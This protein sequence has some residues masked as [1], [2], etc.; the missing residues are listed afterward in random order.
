MKKIVL[1]AVTLSI[2]LAGC[3]TTTLVRDV[4]S[5]D[6]QDNSLG[7]YTLPKAALGVDLYHGSVIATD[8]TTKKE[9]LSSDGF[10]IAAST[11]R[12]EAGEAVPISAIFS[13]SSHDKFTVDVD[14]A[15]GFL[16]RI[17]LNIEDKSV[18]TI[19]AAAASIGAIA[20]FFPNFGVPGGSRSSAEAAPVSGGQSRRVEYA[21]VASVVVDPTDPQSIAAAN[22]ALNTH[23]EEYLSYLHR[24]CQVNNGPRCAR[25]AAWRASP[26][27]KRAAYEPSFHEFISSPYAAK[28]KAAPA[29]TRQSRCAKDV[30]HGPGVCVR[31]ARNVPVMLQ[32]PGGPPIWQDAR[33]PVA[34]DDYLLNVERAM[35]A[36]KVFKV[37]FANGFAGKREVEQSSQALAIAGAPKAAIDAFVDSL[38]KTTTALSNLIPVRVKYESQRHPTSTTTVK[39]TETASGPATN[40]APATQTTTETTTQQES[41]SPEPDGESPKPP[42]AQENGDDAEAAAEPPPQP[43]LVHAPQLWFAACSYGL[44]CAGPLEK[45]LRT[46]GADTGLRESESTTRRSNN[47]GPAPACT[48]ADAG[49]PECKSQE[50]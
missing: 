36:N 11:P 9:T 16:K 18:D 40:G 38:S 37:D 22:T 45:E 32:A 23:V 15:T 19:K 3:E 47:A 39:K 49:K 2:S 33:L 5:E 10:L 34:G 31:V 30:A 12:V 43:S 46:G 35:F 29:Q 48:G 28:A 20:A 26:W 6:A 17:E 14:P 50:D 21:L 7:F 1:A 44:N 13:A 42:V 41:T 24:M 8:S 25:H 27:D 4:S